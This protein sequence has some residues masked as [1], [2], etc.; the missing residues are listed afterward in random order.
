MRNLPSARK[1]GLPAGPGSRTHVSELRAMEG[2]WNFAAL[3]IDGAPMEPYAYSRSQLLIDGDRFCMLS[4]EANYEGV[5]LIDVEAQLHTID[6]HSSPGPK[7][8]TPPSGF[9]S[10]TA[11]IS[12]FASASPV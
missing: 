3:E 12:A 9:L 8:A 5:F 6:I 11:T 10:W 4:P 2:T 7:R 1:E